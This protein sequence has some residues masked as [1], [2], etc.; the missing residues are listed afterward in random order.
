MRDF[1][2]NVRKLDDG[3]MDG[4]IRRQNSIFIAMTLT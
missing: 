1:E 3:W 4:W 2:L